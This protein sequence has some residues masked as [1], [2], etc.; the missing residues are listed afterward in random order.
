M[1][2]REHLLAA[3]CLVAILLTGVPATAQQ[4]GAAAASATGQGDLQTWIKQLESDA[5]VERQEASRQ[6]AGAGV[7]AVYPVVERLLNGPPESVARCT[8]LLS[9]IA[10]NARQQD[11]TRIARVLGLLSENGL[12]HL[13]GE[14]LLL[15]SR[16]KRARVERTVARLNAAGIEVT[17]LD[18]FR[19]ARLG[20]VRALDFS[21][22]E[23][24]SGSPESKARPTR[25]PQTPPLGS[26]EILA[27]VQAII[28]ATE[29]ENNQRFADEIL[30][31]QNQPANID[32][33][34]ALQSG[35]PTDVVVLGGEGRI[36]VRDAG[37]IIMIDGQTISDDPASTPHLVTIG[38]EFHGNAEDLN[39]L[40]LLPSIARLTVVEREI[41]EPLLDLLRS[42]PGIRFVTFSG[43]RYDVS[44]VL[45]LLKTRPDLSLTATGHDAFLG[46]QL[47]TEPRDDG[48]T[49]CR[50]L[51]VVPD[52]AAEAA[53][54]RADDIIRRINGVPVSTYEQVILTIGAFQPGDALTLDILRDETR[55]M[56]LTATLRTRPADR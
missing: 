15:N 27:R 31:Q 37:G 30:S 20:V 33:D 35:L 3:I 52:S 55:E 4:S 5:Y 12:D 22:V 14:S 36:I 11:M 51:E 16:W 6:L 46:V 13:R 56:E 34:H 47:Q 41:D 53:G 43:C 23:L 48:Q 21:T 29:E 44:A 39:A 42:S 1:S 19:G 10:M 8:Q 25:S 32:A 9:R 17:E 28:A 49:A 2:C 18:G 50:V 54:C 7:D 24:N 38:K 45:D 26:D 40:K